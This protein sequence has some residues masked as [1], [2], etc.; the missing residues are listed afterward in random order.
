MIHFVGSQSLRASEPGQSSERSR[1][2]A[3]WV[4]SLRMRSVTEIRGEQV[5]ETGVTSWISI[6]SIDQ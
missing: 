2:S 4:D 3:E 1:V 6:L 5:M